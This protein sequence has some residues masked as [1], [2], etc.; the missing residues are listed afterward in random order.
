M[1]ELN[2]SEKFW[3]LFWLIV[4]GFPF[5]ELSMTLLITLYECGQ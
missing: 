1:S 2:S 3:L 4:F 5:M